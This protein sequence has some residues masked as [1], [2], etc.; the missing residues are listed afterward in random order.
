[1]NRVLVAPL[2]LMCL[3]GSCTTSA[4]LK[5]HAHIGH[6]MTTWHDTP[7]Q[8]G[9]YVVA[10]R[11]LAVAV[12]EADAAVFAA[13]DERARRR[14]LEN[15][16]NALNPDRQPIGTGHGYGAIRALEGAVEHLE[17][18][19]ASEDASDNFVASVVDLADHGDA[20]L[21]RLRRAEALTAESLAA[22]PIAVPATLAIRDALRAASSGDGGGVAGLE[23]RL[24][25]M[26][27][28]ERDPDYQPVSR[29]YVLGLIRLP[30]GVWG[31]RPA[32]RAVARTRGYSGY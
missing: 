27:D 15:V 26:L 8:E 12:S 13:G 22:A 6:A 32:R 3:A 19:A 1:M 29:R 25:A 4:P 11:E 30:N 10:R 5:S 9:L 14:H 17:Y 31:F 24:Q 20:I 18:A 23:S 2:L 28:R 7:G 16:L 21:E